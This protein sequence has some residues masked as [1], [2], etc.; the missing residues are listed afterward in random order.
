MKRTCMAPHAARMLVTQVCIGLDP[1]ELKLPTR[2]AK[3]SRKA[4]AVDHPTRTGI[5]TI[6][7]TAT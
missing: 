1:D 5:S 3:L 6:T 7:V 2:F 4:I